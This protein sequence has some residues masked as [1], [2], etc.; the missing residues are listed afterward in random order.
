M[1]LALFISYYFSRKTDL[2]LPLP[3]RFEKTFA[4]ESKY[5][6]ISLHTSAGN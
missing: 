5:Y 1:K 6:K 3:Q 2:C 4:H